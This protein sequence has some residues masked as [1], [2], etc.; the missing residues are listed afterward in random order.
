MVDMES[1]KISRP[2]VLEVDISNFKYN[3]EQ[4]K[5]KLN[6]ETKIMP[7][8]KANAYGTY[9]NTRLD[10][11]EEF[12]IVAVAIVEEGVALRK[13]GYQKDI[14]VLNQ[15]YSNEIDEIIENDLVIGLSS[16][17]FLKEVQKRN[18]LIRVHLEIET[19]MGRTGIAFEQLERFIGEI[20]QK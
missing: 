12:D 8:I 10:L 6:P 9:I 15:P 19:G 16:Y 11:L 7:V 14:F 17:S 5:N 3:V 13:L 2:T 4:I 18:K 20:K 1:K